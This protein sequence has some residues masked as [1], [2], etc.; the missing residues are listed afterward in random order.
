MTFILYKKRDSKYSYDW[1]R[2]VYRRG[3]L[4]KPSTSSGYKRYQVFEDE[5]SSRLTLFDFVPAENLH[6]LAHGSAKAYLEDFS[7]EDILGEII[8]G[9]IAEEIGRAEQLLL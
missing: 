7:V 1:R 3:D 2:A 6:N 9:S 5:T 8:G 4:Q